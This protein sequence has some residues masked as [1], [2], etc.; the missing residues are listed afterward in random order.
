M[1]TDVFYLTIIVNWT[2]CGRISKFLNFSKDIRALSAATCSTGTE[3]AG[4][5]R[6]G[7]HDEINLPFIF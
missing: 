6:G 4:D 5:I 1:N 7:L 3:P 2:V